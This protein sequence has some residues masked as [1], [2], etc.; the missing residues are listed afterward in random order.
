MP[1]APGPESKRTMRRNVIT[2]TAGDGDLE[3]LSALARETYSD[4]FGH[5]FSATDLAAHFA[6]RLSPESFAEALRGDVILV[7]DAEGRLIGYAQFGAASC[8]GAR[9]G[10]R[11]LRR[12]YVH[13]DFQNQGV[14]TLLMDAALRHPWM[15]RAGSIYLDVWEHNPG[16]RRFYERYGF[17]V[18]GTRSFEVES[19]AET[20][21]DL[22]MVRRSAPAG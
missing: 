21:L 5:T 10:D 9:E 6:R 16:A 11:E 3:A 20:S 1:T 12:L 13:R 8:A 2:R 19:G 17:E 4:A 22:V 14:G 7:A 15:Q 18:I